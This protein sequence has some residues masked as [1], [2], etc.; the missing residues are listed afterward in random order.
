[1]A[2]MGLGMFLYD[3]LALF[4]TPEMHERLSAAG[5]AKRVPILRHDDLV[6]SY[7]YSDAY[8]DDDRLDIETLRAAHQA[9]ACIV[10]YTAAISSTLENG[11]VVAV[12]AVDLKSN[13]KISI[14][15][16]QVVCMVGPW[17]DL[18]GEKLVSDWK[19]LLRPTKGVHLTLPRNR[20]HLPSAIVMAAQESNRIVFAIPRH[21]MII[22]GTTD[23]DFT[24]DP[25]VATADFDDVN[26]LLSITNSYFP[27]ANLGPQD[28]ISSYV[29]VRPLV[30]DDAG[31]EGKTSREHV[32]KSDAR[33][34]H[35]VAGGKYTTYR[36]M[37]EQ[38]VDRVLKFMPVE[39]R[40]QFAACTT[41]SPLNEFVSHDQL[42]L[43][44]TLAGS[45]TEKL[46]VERF[47]MEAFEIL[48]KFDSSLS[49]WQ[50]EAMQAIHQTMCM[51]LLDF[52]TR[53][54][55]LML[56]QR[57]HGI[58][59]MDE[60]AQ[61]FKRELILTNAEVEAQKIELLNYIKKELNWIASFK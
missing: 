38:I 22:I 58:S 32:I 35:F 55:P 30:R 27:G 47:G 17:T 25:S 18:V 9:G 2:K 26:Y 8:M 24:G 59:L 10:N 48:K 11:K 41:H 57:D 4:Q 50:I 20:L 46:L 7:V 19:T 40:L 3:L 45:D 13:K 54:T 23:T 53:R 56:S 6:G 5:T 42:I 49:Y 37:S 52:Y 16:D 12:E 1:M 36:L 14:S 29:G 31:D 15:C 44:A 39:K 28:I 51:N 34:F 21:E 33:G 61:I 43:A 60:V